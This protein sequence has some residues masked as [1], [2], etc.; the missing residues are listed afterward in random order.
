MQGLTERSQKEKDDF[1]VHA[2]D[3]GSG[4]ATVSF[5]FED[6]VGRTHTRSQSVT[7]SNARHAAL[8]VPLRVD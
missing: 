2:V 7:V 1:A 3:L 5:N 6:F 4:T 8:I